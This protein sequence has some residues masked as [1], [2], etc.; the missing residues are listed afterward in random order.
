MA[1]TDY[2]G[3]TVDQLIFQGV[4]ETGNQPIT[5]GWGDAGEI[6]TGAQKVAQ[7]WASLFLTE[8]GSIPLDLERGTG[9]IQAVR[10]AR[11]QVDAD[12]QAEFNLA[13]ER[14]IQTM[15]QDAAAVG[16]MQDDERLDEAILVDNEIDRQMSSLYLKVNKLT[17]A[18]DAREIILPVSVSIR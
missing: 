13:A 11:I 3:R 10:T 12:V 6:C 5:L 14:I 9:F 1:T 4:A 16:K 17:I 8:R 18:G 7:T 2:T 15:D